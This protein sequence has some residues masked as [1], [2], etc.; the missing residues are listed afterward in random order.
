MKMDF[1][2]YFCG[3]CVAAVEFLRVKKLDLEN[4]ALLFESLNVK[5]KLCVHVN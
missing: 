4:A 2:T 5:L 3:F 1:L